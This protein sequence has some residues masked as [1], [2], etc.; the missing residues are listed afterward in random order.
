MPACL[1]SAWPTGVHRCPHQAPRRARP[2]SATATVPIVPPAQDRL[3]RQEDAQQ[4]LKPVL[5]GSIP[6]IA[7]EPGGPFN[8]LVGIALCLIHKIALR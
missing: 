1:P 3:V 8:S 7:E 2:M 4:A 6:A 5:R